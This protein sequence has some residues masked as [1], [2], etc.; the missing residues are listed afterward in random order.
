[1]EAMIARGRSAVSLLTA[2]RS[3]RLV[4]GGVG[5]GIRLYP[6]IF[7]RLYSVRGL[8]VCTAVAAVGGGALT[9]AGG[10]T[11][12]IGGAVVDDNKVKLKIK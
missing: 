8:A 6:L 10:L 3:R 4:C 12:C 11:A 1:M 5:S 7:F 9:V 2:I